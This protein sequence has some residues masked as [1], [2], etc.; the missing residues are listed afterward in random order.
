MDKADATD[1]IDEIKAILSSGNW[2]ALDLGGV[3]IEVDTTDFAK[4]DYDGLVGMVRAKA[5]TG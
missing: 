1:S 2:E 5:G 4:V 3:L